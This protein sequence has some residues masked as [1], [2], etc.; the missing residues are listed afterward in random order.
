MA[1]EGSD[2]K[3]GPER[4][5]QAR[6]CMACRGSG[7][8]ISKLGGETSTVACPWCDGAG[9]RLS[10]HDAQARWGEGQPAPGDG[11]GGAGADAGERADAAAAPGAGEGAHA[12]KVSGPGTSSGAGA[13]G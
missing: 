13:S 10:G 8:V 1:S 12:G 2:N 11:G 5:Q 7:R 4:V 3:D 9:V 6:E